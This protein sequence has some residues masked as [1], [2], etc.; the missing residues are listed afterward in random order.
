MGKHLSFHPDQFPLEFHQVFNG[1]INVY[2][3]LMYTVIKCMSC[4]Q[5]LMPYSKV[6]DRLTSSVT[7]KQARRCSKVKPSSFLWRE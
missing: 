3:N 6:F 2:R 4:K 5:M 1:P 7:Y